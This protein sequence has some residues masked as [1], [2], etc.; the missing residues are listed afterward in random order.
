[1]SFS[2]DLKAFA[3]KAERLTNGAFVSTAVELQKSIKFGSALTG[4]PPMPVANQ[5]YFRA[6]ALRDSVTLTFPS[7]TEA[8][9]YTTK[10]YAPNVEDNTEGFQYDFGAPHG[11][12]L[13]I[14][15]F[16]RV[17]DAVVARQGAT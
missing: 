12:K 2:S 17:V 1:M 11:W 3:D 15:A 6:G 9:I 8:L 7:P 13:T 14:A 10:W 4:A 5:K 16:P